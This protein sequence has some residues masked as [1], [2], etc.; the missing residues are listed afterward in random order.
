MSLIELE[1]VKKVYQLDQTEVAA[2]RGVS[3]SIDRGNSWR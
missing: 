3:L 2:L 1:E